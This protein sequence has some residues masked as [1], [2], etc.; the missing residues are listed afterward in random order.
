MN[1]QAYTLAKHP[2]WVCIQVKAPESKTRTPVHLCCVI[3]TSGSMDSYNKLEDVK[4]SLQFL[5][6]FLSP[7]DS[8]SVITFSETA[9][10]ILSQIAVSA[11]EKD[12]I[13]ARISIIQ[14]AGK[15]PTRVP[16]P[17]KHLR[18]IMHDLRENRRVQRIQILPQ[19]IHARRPH[20][21]RRHKRPGIH[22]PQSKLPHSQ[23]ISGRNLLVFKHTILALQRTVPCH[24]PRETIQTR[25][26]RPSL[27]HVLPRKHSTSK[28]RIAENP[29]IFV[30]GGTDLGETHVHFVAV[31]EVVAV[32]DGHHFFHA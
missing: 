24:I 32:L 31:E 14:H 29:Q 19:L 9:R 30:R 2:E 25:L 5:L 21:R 26:G 6:D 23:P 16:I 22:P 18:Q 20:N 13:R 4:R 8:I 11:N 12:N 15:R 10:T 28:R 1:F 7:E 3:D 27:E 17:H